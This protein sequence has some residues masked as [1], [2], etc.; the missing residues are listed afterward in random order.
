M[1]SERLENYWIGKRVEIHPRFDRWA[2]GDRFGTVEAAHRNDTINADM[3]R[4]RMDKS[5]DLTAFTTDDV[6]E[7]L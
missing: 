7:V 2:R 4:V 1:K 5:G 3:V 6:K